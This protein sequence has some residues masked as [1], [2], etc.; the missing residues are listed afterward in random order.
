ME[1]YLILNY[2]TRKS[3]GELPKIKIGKYCSI[4][5]NCTFLQSNHLLNRFTTYP[6]NLQHLF[7]HKQGNTSGYSR[8]DIIIGHDVWI[9]ANCSILDNVI[10]G[11]GAVIA[12]GS[13]VT[14]NVDA[15]SIV[16]GNPAR[17]IKYR[18][19]QDII[20]R[21]SATNFW[22]LPIEQIKT[23]NLWE[24]DINKILREIEDTL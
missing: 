4:A 10:I 20:K 21:I 5:I 8:G 18:L 6:S 23:F 7:S 2:D 13:I 15:Y 9:G 24:E 17:H 22:E 14:K 12:A 19:P 11:N 16:G 1:P 3:D